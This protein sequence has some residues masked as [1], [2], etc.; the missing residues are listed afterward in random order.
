[1]K[2]F[3]DDGWREEFV[4][5]KG[6]TCKL[7]TDV[8]FPLDSRVCKLAE[9][10]CALYRTVNKGGVPYSVIYD[11]NA[12]EIWSIDTEKEKGMV[13]EAGGYYGEDVTL[14]PADGEFKK[15]IKDLGL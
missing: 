14:P 5:N 15:L 11:E 1:M 3:F 2:L 6:E 7:A 9:G 13:E 4:N 8:K 10:R 12:R